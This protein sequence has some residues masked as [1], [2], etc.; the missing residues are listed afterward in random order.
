MTD[1]PKIPDAFTLSPASATKLGGVKADSAEATDIQPV[2]IGVDGKL[3]TAAG[4][5]DISLGLTSAAV[6]QII[7]VKAIDESGKP[8]EW[9][10][11]DIGSNAGKLRWQKVNEITT[12]EQTNSITLTKDSN[13][14]DISEYNALAIKVEFKIPA[15]ST[16]TDNNGSVW[17]YPYAPYRAA[18]FRVITT[19]SGWKTTQRNNMLLFFGDINGMIYGGNNNG[20]AIA[21]DENDKALVEPLLFNGITLYINVG[22]AANHFPVGTIASVEVLSDKE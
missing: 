12:T 15:D 4:G 10:A 6:G 19:V 20:G 17:V 7:K 14:V 3:Y 1:K 11:V 22:S 9:E 13:G 8:T 2:R 16:Q 18:V 21:N 5:T